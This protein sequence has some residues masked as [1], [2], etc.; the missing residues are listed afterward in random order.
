[1]SLCPRL[2]FLLAL[3]VA[4]M[5]FCVLMVQLSWESSASDSSKDFARCERKTYE[6]FFGAICDLFMRYVSGWEARGMHYCLTQV[7]HVLTSKN[8]IICANFP[9]Y[10]IFKAPNEGQGHNLCI[11]Y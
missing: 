2:H 5:L 6:H 1:M 10:S 7:N 3:L 9:K 11:C 4:D 8:L